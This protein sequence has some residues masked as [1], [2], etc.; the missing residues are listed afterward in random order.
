MGTTD[1]SGALDDEHLVRLWLAGRPDSTVRVYKPVA[2]RFLVV[3]GKTLREATVADVIAWF[4]ALTGA[5]ATIARRVSTV[6]S[7]LTFAW[8]T[9]YALFNVGRVLK[10]VKVTDNLHERIIDEAQVKALVDA[11]PEGRDRALVRL[12][13]VG[14][15][16]I[17]EAVALR[18]IDLG[19]GRVTVKGKG[20]KSR[21][22]AVPETVLGPLRAL[23][24]VDPYKLLFQSYRSKPICVRYAREI[25]YQAAEKAKIDLSPHW[26][27]HAHA[28][29]ALDHGCPIHVLQKGLG[30]ANVSTTSRYLHVRADQGPSQYLAPV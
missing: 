6:K 20:S 19:A 7:L 28:S 11:A 15:L 2:H 4:E 13:Y 14:G 27:R 26:L 22:I 25:V 1:L 12:L 23:A 9:G 24:S 21:T 17:S 8:R 5:T 30:H 10:C 29:H 18:P 16:R 3:L